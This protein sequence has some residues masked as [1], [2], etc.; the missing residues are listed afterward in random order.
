MANPLKQARREKP[1]EAAQCQALANNIARQALQ[2]RQV[3]ARLLK[4]VDDNVA[5]TP[6]GLDALLDCLATQGT[7]G[8]V[9]DQIQDIVARST[10][11]VNA[12]LNTDEDAKTLPISASSV[13]ASKTRK[14][15]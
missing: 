8:D 1:T 4:L 2:V 11:L 12:H 14:G 15:V 13:A 10:D 3:A 5:Q 6:G 9:I 7:A